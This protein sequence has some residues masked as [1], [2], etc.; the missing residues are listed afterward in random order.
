MADI[1]C[2]GAIVLDDQGRLLLVRRGR[3][4]GKGLWSVPG[5]KCESGESAGQACIRETLEETGL[6]VRPLR[7]AGRVERATG[8][9]DVFIIDDF[10]CEVVGGALRAGDDATDARW[11]SA[12]EMTP[13]QLTEGLLEA[14]VEWAAV[15]A[16][17]LEEPV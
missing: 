11:V 5:G 17:W 13:A 3:P 1:P 10:V 4:P 8:S 7:H 6:T 16:H 12:G 15:P 9:G 2:A 14:L